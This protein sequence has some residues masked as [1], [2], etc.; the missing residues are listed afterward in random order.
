V[1]VGGGCMIPIN[2]LQA[3][4]DGTNNSISFP[5]KK[6]KKKKMVKVSMFK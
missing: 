6:K 1:A 2:S 3:S 5:K 4:D